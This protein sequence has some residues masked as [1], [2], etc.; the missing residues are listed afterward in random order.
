MLHSLKFTGFRGF[1]KLELEGLQRVNLIVGKNNSGKTSLLE[2]IAC[3]LDIGSGANHIRRLRNLEATLVGIFEGHRYSR[4]M[5]HDGVSASRIRFQ[6]TWNDEY[7]DFV[8]SQPSPDAESL[9]PAPEPDGVR[10]IPSLGVRS[11]LVPVQHKAP[12]ELVLTVG[13]AVRR[14]QGEELI[15]SIVKSIDPR[16]KKLRIDPGEKPGQ[17]HVVA[18]IGLRRLLPLSQVGQGT[19]RLVEILSEIIGSEAQ[20]CFIDEVENGIHHSCLADIWRG[21]AEA[22]HRFQVQVF[23]TTHSYECLEAAHEAFSARPRYDLGV[24]QLFRTSKDVQG[25]VL[26]Q[27]HIAAAM[28]GEIDLRG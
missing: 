21:I 23:A 9:M 4:W 26:G 22:A 6:G 15:E 14:S 27:E 20:V 17:N 28:D 3:L 13:K 19:Y 8:L 11:C 5:C 16:F 10:R 24:I 1:E 7:I 2:G 12:E 25:R 18:D